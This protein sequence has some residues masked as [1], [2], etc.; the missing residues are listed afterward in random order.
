MTKR[1]IVAAILAGTITLL[2]TVPWHAAAQMGMPSDFEKYSVQTTSYTVEIRTG[3]ELSM[4]S[5]TMTVTDQGKPVNHHVE[6]HIF[7]K[8]TGA[9]VTDLIPTARITD[10]AS[11]TSRLLTNMMACLISKH[12]DREP[13]FG[14][15][16]YLADGEYTI[17]V[18]VS[19]ETAVFEDVVL[20]T[21]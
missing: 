14:D 20:K 9:K 7:N 10:Q 18:V 5:P 17:A 13:H 8:S 3:P 12:R 11:G 15:N 2:G 1:S 16:L 19:S 6:I 21:F 4:A